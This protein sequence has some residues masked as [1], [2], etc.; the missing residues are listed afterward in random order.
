MAAESHLL[1]MVAGEAAGIAKKYMCIKEIMLLGLL[2][3]WSILNIRY[4]PIWAEKQTICADDG[5]YGLLNGP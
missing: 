2:Q 1:A 5:P 4:R 3:P